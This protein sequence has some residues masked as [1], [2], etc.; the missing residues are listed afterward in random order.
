LPVDHP[1]FAT[2]LEPLARVGVTFL[3]ANGSIN[4]VKCMSARSTILCG[5]RDIAADQNIDL[6]PLDDERPLLET[7][8]DS[9][10]F[11]M[12]A[13]RLADVMGCDPFATVSVSRFPRTIG[14]LVALYDEA[15]V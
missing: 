9:L 4:G 12:L 2:D 3:A 10:G 13:S 6:A 7:G 11:A 15:L 14:E 5:I 8:L 1:G